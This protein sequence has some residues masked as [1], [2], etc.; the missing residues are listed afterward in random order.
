MMY[1][2]K[3]GEYY[4][5]TAHLCHSTDIGIGTY[6]ERDDMQNKA[7]GLLNLLGYYWDTSSKAWRLP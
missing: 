4:D 3:C 2:P 7:I 1:C 5:T 6:S